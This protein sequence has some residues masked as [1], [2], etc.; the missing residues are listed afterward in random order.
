MRTRHRAPVLGVFRSALALAVVSAAGCGSQPESG[1]VVQESEAL[2]AGREGSI[3]SAMQR[4]AYGAKYAKKEAPA[5]AEPPKKEA[6]AEAE[7]PK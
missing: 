3:K 7:P 5:K 4:G 2:K 6:P 1:S